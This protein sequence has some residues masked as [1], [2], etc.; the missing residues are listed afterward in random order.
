[1]GQETAR[2]IVLGIGNPDRG[3]DG[4]GR[5]VARQLRGR[6]PEDMELAEISGEATDLLARIEG[7]AAAYV[8]DA[9]ASGAPAGTTRRFDLAAGPLPEAAFGL[10]THGLG[11]ATALEL[12]RALGQLP[13][14]C[15]VYAIEGTS[16]EVGSPLSP[17]V[18][19]AVSA[20]ADRLRA[21][22]AELEPAGG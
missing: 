3:D 16:F 21:E 13:P 5:A 18:V 17:I 22:I 12:A 20:V 14:R 2:R 11:L 4:A 10:S 7:V 1:M 8:V 6:L 19:E 15:I 9:C